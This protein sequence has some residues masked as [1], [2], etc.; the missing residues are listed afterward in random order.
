MSKISVGQAGGT[1]DKTQG[2]AKHDPTKP[3]I[4]HRS[5]SKDCP[6]TQ[7]KQR[8][9]KRISNLPCT[10]QEVRQQVK[11]D[12]QRERHGNDV[13]VLHPDTD[14]LLFVPHQQIHELR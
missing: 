1:Y 8:I 10:S 12:A 4:L 3:N 5:K 2:S 11:A 13:Q 6:E 14:D 7:F 9:E